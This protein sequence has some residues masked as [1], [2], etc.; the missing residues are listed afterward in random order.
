MSRERAGVIFGATAYGLWGLLPLYWLLTAEATS[1]EVVAHRLVWSLVVVLGL[2]AVRARL[3]RLRKLTRRQVIL[4][5]IAAVVITINWCTYIWAVNTSQVIETSLGYFINPLVTVLLGV[6]VL[7]ERL[8]RVQW[9]AMGIAAVAVAVLTVDYGRL[10]WIALTLAGTFATYGFIKKKAGVGAAEGLAVET[11]ALFVPTSAYLIWLEANG[12]ATFGH[13]GWAIDIALI[14][15]GVVTAIPLMFFSAAAT[16]IPLTT[17]GLLQY[18]APTIGFAL[19]VTVFDEDV[20]PVRLA[21]FVL[22]WIALVIFTVD[23]L[24]HGRR[25]RVLPEHP[26]VDEAV[27]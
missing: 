6:L 8:R 11:A 12:T 17:L 9:V 22:V 21:G 13:A 18:L 5:A 2:L 4:L 1:L 25:R 16:R 14:G 10:P 27:R 20:P 15:C 3:H 24:R 26:I 19:G 7:R 23:A